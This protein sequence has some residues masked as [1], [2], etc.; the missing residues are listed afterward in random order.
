[1][2]ETPVMIRDVALI[3]PAGLEA[4]DYVCMRETVTDVTETDSRNL[5][6]RGRLHGGGDITVQDG[7]RGR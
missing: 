6:G 5:N 7:L 2:W 1:M 3:E 4:D